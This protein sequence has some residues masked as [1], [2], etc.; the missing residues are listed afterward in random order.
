MVINTLCSSSIVALHTA[1]Q[2]IRGG[3]CEMAVAGGVQCYIQPTRS[4]ELEVVSEDR[5]T[6]AFDD[7]ANGFGG[8]EAIVSL[9]LKPL[10]KALEDKIIY[11]LLFLEVQ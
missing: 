9:L 3:E 6:R 5:T 7:F 8:G 10:S 2:Y 11:M 4:F 1:C